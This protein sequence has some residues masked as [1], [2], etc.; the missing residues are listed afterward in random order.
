MDSQTRSWT[1][2]FRAGPAVSSAITWD[3]S[4]T[5]AGDSGKVRIGVLRIST[6]SA[7]PC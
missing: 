1:T 7:W 4:T 5:A 3:P 6:T 2:Q